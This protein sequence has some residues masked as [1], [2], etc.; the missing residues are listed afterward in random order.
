M[1]KSQ[2]SFQID[3]ITIDDLILECPICHERTV[4]F[5]FDSD[6]QGYDVYA[7]ANVS[8]MNASCSHC[9]EQFDATVWSKQAPVRIEL[10]VT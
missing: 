3:V 8:R 10:D 6:P 1:D 7:D 2:F 9:G 4:V 5:G